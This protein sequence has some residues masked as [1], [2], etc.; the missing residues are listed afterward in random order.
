M[1]AGRE[2]WRR[3][4]VR[5]RVV[6]ATGSAVTVALV[7]ATLGLA[8]LFAGGRVHDLDR[9]TGQAGDVLLGLVATGQLPRTLPLPAGSPLL[10]QVLASDG[11][12]LAASPAAGAVLP[13][14][15]RPRPGTLTVEQESSAGVPLRVRVTPARLDGA[16][17]L[18][19]V[20]APLG[21]VRRALHA[22]RIALLL[23]V[24]VLVAVTTW[25]V[26]LAAGLALRPVERLRVAAGEQADRAGTAGQTAL[27]PVPPGD[28]EVARLGR[29]LN[30]LLTALRAVVSRQ[31]IFVADAAHELRSPLSALRVQLEVAQ[32]H[33]GTVVLPELLADL[34]QEVTRLSQLAEDL[35]AL[36][37]AEADTPLKREPVDLRGLAAGGTPAVVLG[38]RPALE[39]LLANLVSNAQRA[40]AT[41]RTTSSAQDGWAVLDVDDDG[42][43]IP[44]HDR[45]RVF[46]RWVRL[47]VARTHDDGGSGLGLA[48]ARETARRLGGDLE[49]RDSDL[50]GARLR[51]RLPLAGSS[52]APPG[53][54]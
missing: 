20:A 50:G 41:V 3:Q 18:V 27:L 34:G 16:P 47:D 2:L 53:A 1:R 54:S 42:P 10:A 12:V 8:L 15:A 43:G 17:V 38:D 52:I 46:E 28:D 51:L 29:T 6:V 33:P 36:A 44:V 24:P 35:L 14:L 13:L 7:A 49:V 39:R 23:I 31:Q 19:V 48:L 11:T 32:A 22:L 26:W 9:E 4:G 30:G 37:R 21:D 25:L 40:G 45:E 5:T